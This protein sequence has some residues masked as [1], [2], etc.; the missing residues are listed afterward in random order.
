L[1]ILN[2]LRRVP[3]VF[4][5]FSLI[6]G[7]IYGGGITGYLLLL[8]V[9]T[10]PRIWG[11]Q[12]YPKRVKEKVP[13][14]TRRERILAGILGTPFLI[15]TFS[16][17]LYSV[18]ALKTQLGGRITFIDAFLHLLILMTLFTFGDLVLLDWLLISKITPNFVIIPGSE[19][20]DYKDFTHHYWSHLRA[21]VIMVILSAVIAILVEIKF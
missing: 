5:S 10:S 11:Y 7:L 17:P 4:I 2:I 21:A 18:L 1:W 16:F 20:E 13:P 8:M 6:H 19:A 14:Q 12:D 9:T 3:R 15:F